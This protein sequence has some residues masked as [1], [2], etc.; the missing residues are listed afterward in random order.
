MDG[1][2]QADRR[3]LRVRLGWML[4]LWLAGVAAVGAVAMLLR[5]WLR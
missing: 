2:D 4:L 3:P 5:F 1:P